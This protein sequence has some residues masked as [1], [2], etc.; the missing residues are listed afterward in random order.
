MQPKILRLYS[1]KGEWA[2]KKNKTT[3]EPVEIAKRWKHLANIIQKCSSTKSNF[4]INSSEMAV[5]L[6]DLIKLCAF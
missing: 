5:T 2:R 4:H 3:N 1:N 6:I